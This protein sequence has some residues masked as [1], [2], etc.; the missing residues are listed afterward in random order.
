MFIAGGRTD[1]N[2]LLL[3]ET[4]SGK[5]T[6]INGLA[7]CVSFQTLN[8]AE[9]AHGSFPIRATFRVI[10]PETYKEQLIATDKSVGQDD[11]AAGESVTQEPRTYSFKHGEKTI[12]VID[13]PG[14][15]DTTDTSSE[16]H[17]RD[18]QHVDN[19]L[20]FIGRFDKL[21]AICI[22]LKPNQSRITKGFA[23]CI[24]E[25]LRNLHES[26]SNNVIFIISNAK[27]TDFTPGGV[28]DG[29]LPTLRS[30]LHEN[31]LDRIRL[32][33][34]T[35][36]CIENDTMQHIAEHVNGMKLEKNAH[37]TAVETWKRSARTTNDMLTYIQRL[38]PHDI[39]AT[40]SIHNT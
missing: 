18:K 27:S 30:F 16:T 8:E 24:T 26:A 31:S 35:I 9:K 23:Y 17:E 3:G 19:I 32:D 33:R 40:L 28:L 21:H 34:N 36:Y 6:W 22:L 14:L 15:S 10:N 1:I 38:E 11:D 25:I 4:G 13:K 39:D 5:S 20:H 29:T 2:L 12:N 7:N 37:E